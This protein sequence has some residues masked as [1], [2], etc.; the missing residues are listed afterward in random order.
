MAASTDLAWPELVGVEELQVASTEARIE[1]EL[2][3]GRHHELVAELEALVRLY[4]RA[5]TSTAS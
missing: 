5:S 3:L 1:A 4:P 2:A